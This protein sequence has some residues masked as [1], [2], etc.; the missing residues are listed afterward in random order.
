MKA[1][2][3]F[4]LGRKKSYPNVLELEIYSKNLRTYINT[5]VRVDNTKYWDVSRQ[6]LSVKAPNALAMNKMLFQLKERIE[7]A[8]LDAI[9]RGAELTKEIIKA[10]VTGKK[11]D[12]INTIALFRQYN[13]TDY[14]KNTVKPMTH[15]KYS[16]IL[17]IFQSFIDEFYGEENSILDLRKFDNKILDKLEI[18]LQARYKDTTISKYNIALKKFVNRAVLEKIIT[19]NPYLGYKIAKGRAKERESL[20]I[21]ELNRLENLDRGAMMSIDA[22]LCEVLDRFLLSCYC[23]LRISDNVSLKKREV[24]S[25]EHGLMID[26][27]T[28]KMEGSRVILP[29]KLLFDGKGEKIVQYYLDKYPETEDVFP[30]IPESKINIRL[31]TIAIMAKIRFNLTFHTA[32]HTCATL[33]AEKTGNPF[34]IMKILGHHDIKTSMIY[35]H[36]SYQATINGLVNVK[37]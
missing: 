8:E 18:W 35:I 22:R 15:Q 37:W 11:T 6:S 31:K 14:A 21:E 4:I 34:I 36:N 30:Y 25:T 23:G 9:N 1:R 10:A 2:Y 20:T 29:L 19:D 33:L 17:N 3:K 13:D 24:L 32:R 26:K 5:G 27:V 12:E 28:E 7:A 16:T